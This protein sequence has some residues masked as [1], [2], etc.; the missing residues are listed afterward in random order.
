[1]S[2]GQGGGAPRT[3]SRAAVP[4]SRCYWFRAKPSGLGWDLPLCWQGWGV[5]VLV[6]VAIVA[7]FVLFPPGRQLAHF[8]AMHGGIVL[9]LLMACL[10]KGEPLR[11]G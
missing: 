1:M 2:A 3:T 8:L 9:V 4:A 6:L 10:W 5:Y 7:S 11:R